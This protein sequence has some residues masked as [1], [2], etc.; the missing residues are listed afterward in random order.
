[1]SQLSYVP[2]TQG[3]RLG[4]LNRSEDAIGAF[5]EV[6][7][8]FGQASEPALRDVAAMALKKRGG[9]GVCDS[10]AAVGGS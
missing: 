5:D 2:R 7:R 8:R 9:S 1:M 3:L 4:R 10:G 6:V